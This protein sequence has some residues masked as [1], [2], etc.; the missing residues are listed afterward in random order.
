MEDGDEF[1]LL[2]L[3]L[4]QAL[5]EGG[6]VHPNFPAATGTLQLNF[7][8][9]PADDPGIGPAGVAFFQ[10]DDITH[11]VF[12]HGSLSFLQGNGWPGKKVRIVVLESLEADF[13]D[14]SL[15]SKAMIII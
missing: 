10:G 9:C 11:S 8:S 5:V 2:I 13:A 12:D 4:P 15:G 14:F 1:S 6:S 7:G 3:N